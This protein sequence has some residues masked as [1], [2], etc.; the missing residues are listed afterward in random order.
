M[1]LELFKAYLGRDD[2]YVEARYGMLKEQ[3]DARQQQ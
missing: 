2:E 3:A 1:T